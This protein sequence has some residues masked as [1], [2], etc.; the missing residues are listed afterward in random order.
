MAEAILRDL[1]ALNMTLR[2][3]VAEYERLVGALGS[4][5]AMCGA[6]AADLQRIAGLGARLASEIVRLRR[7]EEPDEELRQAAE[8]GIAVVPFIDPAY[9]A[10]L[11]RIP[12][13]PLV[14][15]VEGQLEEADAVAL[16]VVGS[17]RPT[18]YGTTQA[19]RLTAELAAR[20]LTIVS[21]LARG[22]DTAAHRAALDGGGRT[23]AVLGSG[24]AKLYPAE[25]APLADEIA[26]HGAL[27][28]EFPLH[29]PPWPANFP[30]RNRIVSGLALGV[31]VV[32]AGFRSGALVT[33]DWAL[34][35]GRE[36][37]AL[38]NRV[39][40]SQSRGC[41]LL[42]KQGAKLVEWAQDIVDGLG[43]VGEALAPPRP[44]A[45]EALPELS[46]DEA[47]I[48]KAVPDEPVHIDAITDACALPPHAVASLLMVLE[49]KKL[50]VQLPGKQFARVGPPDGE[51]RG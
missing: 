51:A 40:R 28:S 48:L 27:V 44:K 50:V 18:L 19:A 23:L 32:E 20:G 31:L 42:I 11:R 9:P 22:T 46:R 10:L 12:D 34:D 49:L 36:V 43:E 3:G 35:Q 2:L 21:G 16:A 7:C 38:P 13:A 39:D 47:A 14:L 17:R 37:F 5:E 25:N 30:R 4:H 33:A 26:A 8:R 1:V 29:T 24:L 41:H 6:S 45:S 15:Y